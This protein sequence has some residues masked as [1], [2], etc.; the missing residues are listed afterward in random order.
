[1]KKIISHFK[2]V[3][4]NISNL[5]ERSGIEL[6]QVRNSEKYFDALCYDVIGQQLNGKVAQTIRNRFLDL[7]PGRE[8]TPERTLEVDQD[9]IR[10]T[11]MAWSKVRCIVDLSQRIV[12]G[13]LDLHKL[14]DLT[15]NEVVDELVKVKGIGPWTAEMFLM[16]T[17]GREDIFSVRDLGLR[18]AVIN[19]YSLDRD[20]SWDDIEKVSERW[21]PY[22]TYASLALWKSIDG[23][24]D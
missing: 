7:F 15:D 8:S 13:E 11:G 19:I 17:L 16:F 4:P 14:S 24:L 3:D 22:R 12:D 2:K 20:A 18:K 5:I 23:E 10:N 9:L 6:V 1:M 21:S